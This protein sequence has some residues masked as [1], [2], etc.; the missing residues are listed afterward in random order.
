MQSWFK[1]VAEYLE[2]TSREESK[3]ITFYEQLAKRCKSHLQNDDLKGLALMRN[4]FPNDY[5]NFEVMN[6]SSWK[7]VT[8]QELDELLLLL[9]TQHITSL[10][11]DLIEKWSDMFYTLCLTQ[12]ATPGYMMQLG[13]R[14]SGARKD[15]HLQDSSVKKYKTIC[16]TL[17]F[18][19]VHVQK[20][21]LPNRSPSQCTEEQ[22][23]STLFNIF[24]V[25]IKICTD[26][27]EDDIGTQFFFQKLCRLTAL[28][29]RK[30]LV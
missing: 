1:I 12:S 22:F 4:K 13:G 8:K 26:N 14:N 28:C 20:L 17:F 25:I 7:N 11:K 6:N 5:N 21:S 30:R 3:T 16:H 2:T 18:L 15:I 27:G 29:E 24:S 9:H 10:D 19:L 23:G